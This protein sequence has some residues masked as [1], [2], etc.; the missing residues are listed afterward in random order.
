M[1]QRGVDEMLT[2]NLSPKE[3]EKYDGDLRRLNGGFV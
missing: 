1:F 2:S 3:A